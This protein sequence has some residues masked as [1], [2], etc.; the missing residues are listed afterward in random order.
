MLNMHSGTGLDNIGQ[1]ISGFT[2]KSLERQSLTRFC[3]KMDF[4]KIVYGSLF[5]IQYTAP[6]N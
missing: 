4:D 3:L 6:D 1:S 2:E 5:D